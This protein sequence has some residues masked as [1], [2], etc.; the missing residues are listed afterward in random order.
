MIERGKL[1]AI[2]NY[3]PGM[4]VSLRRD[5]GQPIVVR[6]SAWNYRPMLGIYANFIESEIRHRIQVFAE[7]GGDIS[8]FPLNRKKLFSFEEITGNKEIGDIICETSPLLFY[9]DNCGRIEQHRT[10]DKNIP[11]GKKCPVC[12]K[13]TMKQLQFT[14]SCHCGFSREISINPNE[15]GNFFYFPSDKRQYTLSHKD[16]TKGKE[17][18]L[19]CPNCNTLLRVDNASS[20]RNFKHQSVTVINLVSDDA[21]KFFDR[22]EIAHKTVICRWFGKLSY[23]E[24]DKIIENQDEAFRKKKNQGPLDNFDLVGLVR[25]LSGEN[26]NVEWI[27]NAMCENYKPQSEING[28]E[29]YSEICD[30][31][32]REQIGTFGDDGYREW[33]GRLAYKLIQYYTIRDSIHLSL[34]MCMADMKRYEVIEDYEEVLSLHKIL[35]ISDMLVTNNTELVSCVYGFT[36][37]TDDPASPNLKGRLKLNSFGISEEGLHL[38]YG[39]KLKTEGILFDISLR[40]I[41]EWLLENDYVTESQLPDLDSDESVKHWYLTHV[42]GDNISSFGNSQPSDLITDA[43]FSLL[44][45]MAH[46]FM[47]EAGEISGLDKNSLAELIIVETASIFIYSQSEQGITLGALSGMANLG[48]V[49]F[50]KD[51]LRDSRNCVF[52]PICME[53]ETCCSA[54]QLLPENSCKYFNHNLGRKYLYT[55][56]DKQQPKVGFWDMN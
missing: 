21:G 9:C 47:V 33:I 31:I 3:L 10:G 40:R 53:T 46:A 42:K 16:G 43:V 37:T 56:S 27:L 19:K 13:G 26:V 35:G 28:V 44:H 34:D 5:D 41:I 14:Y 20:K 12:K 29:D 54:C 32:F 8:S 1:Q 24:Y 30:G 52:D 25:T 11:V 7:R 17:L 45:S 36:R 23:S 22:G 48:Y 55:L 51:V 50:L 38:S 2:Y 18:N 4:W 6:I 15:V 39:A 49:K